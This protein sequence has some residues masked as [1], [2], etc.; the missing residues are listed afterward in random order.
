MSNNHVLVVDDEETV[1]YVVKRI[2][3]EA[4][5]IVSVA[6][7]GPECLEILRKGFKG[8]ILMDIIMPGMDGW[9]TI[10]AMVDEGLCEGNI[11]CMLTG[12]PVPDV[13]MDH[14]KEYVLDYIRKPF[15]SDKL[16][17]IVS[18]YLGYLDMPQ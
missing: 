5:F 1:R 10:Q 8:L 17:Q 7:N 15:D 12:K 4:G 6:A 11:V 9:D 14:L 3:E 18:E 13:K 2:L 16:V